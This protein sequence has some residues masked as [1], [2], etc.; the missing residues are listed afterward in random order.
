[1]EGTAGRQKSKKRYHQDFNLA[2]KYFIT[3]IQEAVD[4]VMMLEGEKKKKLTRCVLMISVIAE[5]EDGFKKLLKNIEELVGK[6][7]N[8]PINTNKSY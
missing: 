8:L 2:P 4:K 7:Y 5:V 6:E 1:M 3:Y